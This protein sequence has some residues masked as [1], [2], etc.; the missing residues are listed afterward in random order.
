MMTAVTHD[1]GNPSSRPFLSALQPVNA[2]RR[3][4]ALYL[5]AREYE[6]PLTQYDICKTLVLADVFQVI[7]TGKPVFG[8]TLYALPYGPVTDGTLDACTRWARGF[9]FTAALMAHFRSSTAAP[10]EKRGTTGTRDHISIFVAA[11]NYVRADEASWDW[12][13]DAEQANVRRA[14]DKVMSMTFRRSQSYFHDPVSAIGYAYDIATRPF[15][16]PFKGRIEMNWFDVLDGAEETE[17]R[18]ASYARA[19]LGLWT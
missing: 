18:D 6:K 3:D 10:L 17:K 13:S 12:F 15:P 5:L 1:T 19:M 7:E 2:Q 14:Y 16:K 11:S 4:D 9:V 8:G